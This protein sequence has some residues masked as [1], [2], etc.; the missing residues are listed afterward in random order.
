MDAI[1]DCFEKLPPPC[2]TTSSVQGEKI[3]MS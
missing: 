1:K 2:P 3:V